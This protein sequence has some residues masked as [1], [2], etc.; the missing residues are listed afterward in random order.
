MEHDLS[1]LPLW[2]LPE[3]E[4]QEI[5]IFDELPENITYPQITPVFCREAE[6][7]WHSLAKIHK[8]N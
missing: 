6:K 3:S 4:I 1:Q 5:G 7:L 2:E 8:T